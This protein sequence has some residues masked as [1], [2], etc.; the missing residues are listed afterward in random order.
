MWSDH[1]EIDIVIL[2]LD[3]SINIHMHIILGDD[4]CDIVCVSLFCR[5]TL[6]LIGHEIVRVPVSYSS[7][8]I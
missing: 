1:T 7:H 2:I 4:V 3:G 6:V 5:F 8:V